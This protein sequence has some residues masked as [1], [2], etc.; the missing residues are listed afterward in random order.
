ME[1]NIGFL[2]AFEG[3]DG[4]GKSTLSQCVFQQLSSC[5]LPVLLTREPGATAVGQKMRSLVHEHKLVPQAEFLLFCADRAE[6]IAHVVKPALLEGKIVLSDRMADSSRA[7]QGYGRGL[8]LSFI[9]SV[10]DF[11]MQGVEPDVVIYSKIDAETAF[12]R[13]IKRNE[14]LTVFEKEKISFFEKVINGFEEI[15]RHK[16]NV[17]V[18]DAQHT[19]DVLCQL[20]TQEIFKRLENKRLSHE[21]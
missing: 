1:K 16:K 7:Y 2:I 19:P 15:F 17:F 3:I 6:H 14:A 18:V 21:V 12:S 8:D 10:T 20:V 9:D 11:V 4:S 13:I 5:S